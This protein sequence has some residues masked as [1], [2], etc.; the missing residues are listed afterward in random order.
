MSAD[1]GTLLEMAKKAEALRAGVEQRWSW[2]D[3]AR[4]VGRVIGDGLLRSAERRQAQLDRWQAITEGQIQKMLLERWDTAVDNC[5]RPLLD[6]LRAAKEMKAC[7]DRGVPRLH[8]ALQRIAAAA[9][10]ANPATLAA[11]E[12]VAVL[13]D[14]ITDWTTVRFEEWA[15]FVE[16]AM[17]YIRSVVRADPG[18]V[19]S[20]M[21][22]RQMRA[23]CEAC[24]AAARQ[25]DDDFAV[26]D[27]G[28]EN[29]LLHPAARLRGGAAAQ[30]GRAPRPT[31][32]RATTRRHVGAHR[33]RNPRPDRPS[34]RRARPRRARGR[35][36][37]LGERG[38]RQAVPASSGS[39]LSTGA[40]IATAGCPWMSWWFSCRAATASARPP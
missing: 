26:D 40:T 1:G 22:D 5:E 38:D 25:G 32:P 6:S 21:L 29:G 9:E 35:C 8:A 15:R 31:G 28:V 10:D 23:F 13:V 37:T 30:A 19:L 18:R 39:Q 2:P 3:V 33:R 17:T 36:G 11:A 7:A 27:R 4:R 24:D 20:Q 16:R 12:D 14:R 34:P